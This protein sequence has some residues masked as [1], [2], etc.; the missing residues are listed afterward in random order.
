MAAELQNSFLVIIIIIIL[1][2]FFHVF[3]LLNYPS[4]VPCEKTVSWLSN[5]RCTKRPF[6]NHKISIV[7]FLIRL[8]L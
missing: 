7:D 1:F 3:P 6:D 5:N 4:K 8:Q 2:F